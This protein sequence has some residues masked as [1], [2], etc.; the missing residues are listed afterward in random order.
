MTTSYT[1]TFLH[2]SLQR[3]LIDSISVTLSFLMDALA[4]HSDGSIS[5]VHGQL[6]S[7]QISSLAMR[8]FSG[9]LSQV[10]GDSN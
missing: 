7:L 1:K 6:E 4:A 9:Q 2:A 8:L 10:N 5:I 3:L